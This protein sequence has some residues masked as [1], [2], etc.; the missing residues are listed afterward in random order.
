MKSDVTAMEIDLGRVED[1]STFSF[2]GSFSLPTPEGGEAVCTVST[3]ADVTRSGSRYDVAVRVQGEMRVGCHRC[4]APFSMPLDVKFNLILYRGER[5]PLPGGAEENDFVAIP[6]VGE[7]LY[8]IFPRVWEALILEIPI[9]LVCR[10]DC[11]GVCEG[12]GV[13]LNEEDCTCAPGPVDPRWGPLR[14]FLN[15]ESKS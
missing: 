3:T 4:L 7:M 6:V 2:D 12:C 14:K 11:K 9:K 8:D 5:S 15:G 1:R 10:E 13:N